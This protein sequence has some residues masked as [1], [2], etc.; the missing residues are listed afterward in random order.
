MVE[1]EDWIF[2][3]VKQVPWEFDNE[4]S[5]E[6]EK[7]EGTSDFVE[8]LSRKQTIK[9]EGAFQNNFLPWVHKLG[10]IVDRDTALELFQ[11]DEDGFPLTGW[12]I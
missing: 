4:N 8:Q 1:N 6:E 12:A 5:D 10:E 7:K 2:Y 9:A 11:V 3:K